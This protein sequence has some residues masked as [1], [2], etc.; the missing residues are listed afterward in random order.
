MTKT[1]FLERM[2][3]LIG[4]YTTKNN[5]FEDVRV[6]ANCISGETDE[7]FSWNISVVKF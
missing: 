1:E 3:N 5:E 7:W 6:G 4:E 2:R